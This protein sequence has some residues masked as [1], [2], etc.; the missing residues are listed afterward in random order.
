MVVLPEAGLPE[1]LAWLC[2]GGRVG[3]HRQPI[4][5]E[6]VSHGRAVPGLHHFLTCGS[7]RMSSPEMGRADGWQ[8]EGLGSV[9]GTQTNLVVGRPGAGAAGADAGVGAGAGD[10]NS[11]NGAGC[12]AAALPL[13]SLASTLLLSRLAREGGKRSWGPERVLEN[14]EGE[15]GLEAWRW[16]LAR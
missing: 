13:Q 15:R 7:Q 2:R 12:S 6:R 8:E 11:G 4:R 16:S 14:V 1:P 5:A 3:N 10:A 9:G